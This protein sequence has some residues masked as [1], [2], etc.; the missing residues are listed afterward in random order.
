MIDSERPKDD[1]LTSPE[2]S[3]WGAPQYCRR[4]GR[5]TLATMKEAKCDCK[6]VG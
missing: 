1:Q 3:Q 6:G 2:V 4:T 5:P